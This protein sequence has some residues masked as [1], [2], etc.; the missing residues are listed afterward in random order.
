MRCA[1]IRSGESTVKGK[2]SHADLGRVAKIPEMDELASAD[3]SSLTSYE[4]KDG[5][6]VLVLGSLLLST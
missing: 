6:L 1:R 2:R 5:L 3:L 4:P